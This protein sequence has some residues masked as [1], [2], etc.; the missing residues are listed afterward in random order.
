MMRRGGRR[1]GG[2]HE[3]ALALLDRERDILLRGPLSDLGSIV[4][5]REAIVADLLADAPPEGVLAALR[6]RA[7]RNARLLLASLSGLRSAREQVAAV[8]RASGVLKTYDAG[9][10]AVEVS[11]K[12][13][14]QDRRR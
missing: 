7:E 1:R 9:G 2:R 6:Q 5:A 10:R 4:A 3:E 14:A 13:T 12:P 8:E 11:T